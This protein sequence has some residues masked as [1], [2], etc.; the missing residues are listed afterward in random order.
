[1]SGIK[2]KVWGDYACFTRPEMKAERVSYDAMT[3]SAARAILSA[4]YWKPEI[5]W[6]IDKIHVLRQI[7]FAN[8]RRNELGGDMDRTQRF[9]MLLRDVEYM[10]EAHFVIING[11]ENSAKHLEMFNRRAAAG[12]AFFQPYLGCRE[13]SAHFEPADSAPHGFYSD[14]DEKDLGIMLYDIDFK[15]NK[16]PQF[17]RAKMTGGVI[18]TDRG[19]IIK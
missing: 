11:E 2:L 4:I 14:S 18:D 10:I 6:I 13:F 15:N 7:K 12:K 19:L 8:V 3:P 5:E 16:T 1:M 9:S 17:F